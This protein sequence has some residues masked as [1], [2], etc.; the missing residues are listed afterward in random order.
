MRTGPIPIVR[1]RGETGQFPALD[2][3][4]VLTDDQS[5]SEN[6]EDEQR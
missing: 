5:A 4:Y 2:E 6:P 1:D 3:T